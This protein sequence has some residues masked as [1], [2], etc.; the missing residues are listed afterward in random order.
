MVL[1]GQ[2][3]LTK[4]PE[5]CNT[6]SSGLGGMSHD[7]RGSLESSGQ[8]RPEEPREQPARSHRSSAVE[9]G[10]NYHS[11]DEQDMH[12]LGVGKNFWFDKLQ[13]LWPTLKVLPVPWARRRFCFLMSTCSAEKEGSARRWRSSSRRH[14]H[15]DKGSFSNQ[16]TGREWQ[17]PSFLA[18]KKKMSLKSFYKSR[19]G[20]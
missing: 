18:W 1:S 19:F 6:L 12:F 5:T 10:A 4:F 13:I 14:Y 7:Q 3:H 11:L 17:G 20:S 16:A 15:A 9:A 2:L 8:D